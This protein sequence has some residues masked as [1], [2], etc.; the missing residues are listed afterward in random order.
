MFYSLGIRY[1]GYFILGYKLFLGAILLVDDRCLG[2]VRYN[3]FWFVFV[4]YKF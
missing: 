2:V 3:E 1:L 4:V